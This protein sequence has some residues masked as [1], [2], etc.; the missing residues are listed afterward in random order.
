[1]PAV[2]APPTYQRRQPE[3]SVLYRTLHTHLDTFLA[4]AGDEDGGSLPSFV[5]R[6]LRAYLRCGVLSHGLV[7]VRCEKCEGEMVVAFS[8]C[9]QTDT[10]RSLMPRA[11]Q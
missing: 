3:A 4:R 8:C 10:M 6:E 5:T 1:M 11:F 9:L 2:C 7:H